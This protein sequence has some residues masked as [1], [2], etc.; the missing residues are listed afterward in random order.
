MKTPKTTTEKL[1]AGLLAMGAVEGTK[2]THYR[3]F[4]LTGVGTLFVGKAGALRISRTG[5]VT[6]TA[7]CNDK[8]RA[9]VLA[10]S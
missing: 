6:K 4:E 8:Y 3:R 2:T 1:V 10:A 5:Q 7:K 9:K